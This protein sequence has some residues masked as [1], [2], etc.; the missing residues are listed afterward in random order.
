[1]SKDV[2]LIEDVPGLGEQGKRLKV[3][4]GYARN[5]LLPRKLATPVTPATLRQLEKKKAEYDAR[6]IRLAE[7]A[8]ALADRLKAL[9]LTIKVKAGNEGK[10]FGSVTGA[11]VLQALKDEKYTLEKHQVV[12]EN[13][14]KELGTYGVAIKLTSEV[15]TTLTVHVVAE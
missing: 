5:Y 1:M 2:I 11:Q 9:E 10:I 8:Q 4:D 13:P 3:S 15:H 6:R 14:I 7:E 12:L